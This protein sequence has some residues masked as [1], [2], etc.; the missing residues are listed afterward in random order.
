MATYKSLLYK[1]QWRRASGSVHVV[2]RELGDR[3]RCHAGDE[4]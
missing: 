1:A 3:A 2:R 4:K